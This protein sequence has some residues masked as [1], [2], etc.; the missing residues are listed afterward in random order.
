MHLHKHLHLEEE[1]RL[2][3]EF[4]KNPPEVNRFIAEH[5]RW[6]T[7]EELRKLLG[8]EEMRKLLGDGGSE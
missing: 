8:E 3:E 5:S 1:R 7:D 4:M 6:P 2:M